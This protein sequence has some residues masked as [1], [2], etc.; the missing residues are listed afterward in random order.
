MIC[1]KPYLIN[2]SEDYINYNYKMPAAKTKQTA[3]EWLVKELNLEGYDYTIS[4]AKEMEKEQ[5]E[6][7]HIEGQRVFDKY[8]HTVW[9]NNQA[10]QYYEQTYAK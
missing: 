8:P 4:Q 5:I 6:D 9:T 10:E 2:M 1:G 7:A 3:V